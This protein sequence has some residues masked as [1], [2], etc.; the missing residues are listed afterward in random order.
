MRRL[1][2]SLNLLL[3]VAPAGLLCLFACLLVQR[4]W[5]YLNSG[6]RLAGIFS[7]EATRALGREVRVQSV[8]F[9]SNPWS[10]LPNR[11]ELG[12]LS[13]ANGPTSQTGYL[14]RAERIVI[15]YDLRQALLTT[16]PTVPL[17]K[18]VALTRPLVSLSRDV[19]GRWNFAQLIKPS[20]GTGRSFT[21][22]ITFTNAG[23]DY[24]DDD[25]PRPAGVARQP[26]RTSI[27]GVDGV[28]L[29]RPDK[30]VAFDVM[31]RGDPVLLRDFHVIGVTTPTP[32]RIDAQVNARDLALSGF[33]RRL[34]PPA[35]GRVE[36]G[37][38]DVDLSLLYTAPPNAPLSA[39]DL[40]SLDANGMVTLRAVTVSSPHLAAPLRD[41][42]GTLTLTEDSALGNL[43]GQFAGARFALT[44]RAVD[45]RSVV[46]AAGKSRQGAAPVPMV[47]LQG[48]VE[49]AD[50]GKI[51]HAIN[52]DPH[53][54][55]LAP[56]ARYDILNAAARGNL[57]F[58]FVGPLTD[59]TSVVEGHLELARYD[60]YRGDQIDLRAFYAH[61]TVDADARGRFAHGDAFV[62]GHVAA[63][64]TG[65]F[66]IEAHGRQLHLSVLKQILGLN[67][68]GVGQLD[69][70]I[71]GQRH[72][73]PSI[74][75]QGEVTGL[76]YGGQTLRSVYAYAATVGDPLI[77]WGR[78]TPDPLGRKKLRLETLR[79]DDA[80]GFA[81]A[82]GLL[83]LRTQKLNL[84]VEA[85]EL[86][87]GA[88]ASAIRNGARTAQTTNA[89]GATGGAA[90]AAGKPDSA[91]APERDA[92]AGALEPGLDLNALQGV[93]Y[94]RARVG[95]TLRHPEASGRVSAFA[96][97]AGKAGL[98]SVT[99]DFVL[100]RDTLLLQHAV[101]Q[102]YPGAVTADGSISDLRSSDPKVALTARIDNADVADLLDISGGL[103]NT[104]LTPGQK[105][106]YVVT[107]RLFA[108]PIAVTGTL[109]DLKLARPVT[110]SL[111]S[112]AINN[113]SLPLVTARA[114]YDHL[115][116]HLEE[117]RVDV[118]GG[119]ITARGTGGR[120]GLDLDVTGTGIG[121]QSLA[122]ALPATKPVNG[123]GMAAF[124]PQ[125]VQGAL[126][127][128]AHVG[129]TTQ[130]PQVSGSAAVADLG[131]R[132]MVLGNLQATAR[133]ADRR[134]S[135][136]SA[137]VREPN[138]PAGQPDTI[139]VD[140][141]A[142]NLQ[143]KTLGGMLRLNNMRLERA[144]DLFT[145]EALANT[146][147]G[148]QRSAFTDTLVHSVE[149][150]LSG[151][152]KIGG[153][154]EA[155]VA[156]VTW[157]ANNI[158]V[159]NQVITSITGSALADIHHL[160]IPSPEHPKLNLHIDSPDATVV[161]DKINYEFD[162]T[163]DGKLV[164]G[165]VA[166]DIDAYNVDL[167]LI[168]NWLP[169]QTR[170]EPFW[171]GVARQLTG[172]GRQIGVVVHGTSASPV[173]DVSA[174][175]ANL[176]YKGFNIDRVNLSRAT[177]AEPQITIEDIE[178][179]KRLSTED[180]SGPEFIARVTNGKIGMQWKSPFVPVL[181]EDGLFEI[182]ADVPH[183]DL[184]ALNA[185]GAFS[186]GN[187]RQGVFAADTTGA[188]EGHAHLSRV[189]GDWMPVGTLDIVSNLLHLENLHTGLRNLTAHLGF[190]GATVT[191]SGKAQ[192][193][194]YD[195][196]NLPEAK[197]AGGEITL[198]GSLPLTSQPTDGKAPQIT[199]DAPDIKVDETPI[200]GTAAPGGRGSGSL[201]SE[202]ALQLAM[203]R[204]LSQPL[205]A[206]TVN[207]SNSTLVP[208]G[209]FGGTG[210]GAFAL[211]INPEFDLAINLKN[212]NRLSNSLLNVRVD[213]SS[214]L[215]GRLFKKTPSLSDIANPNTDTDATDIT[216]VAATSTTG[217]N[218]A[219]ADEETATPANN[220]A[221]NYRGDFTV[222][223][224]RLTLPTA[225]FTLLPPGT[226]APGALTVR[227][228][229]F[230]PSLPGQQVLGF[231]VNLAAQTY[232]NLP[233]YTSV[234]G[235]KRYLVTVIVRGKPVNDPVTGQSKLTLN[236]QTDPP[237]F[238]GNQQSLQQL[239]VGVLGGNALQGIGR[240]PGQAIIQQFSNVLSSTVIP[241]IFD[242]PAEALGLEELAINYD[243]VQRLNLVLSRRII[244]SL[245]V[246]YIRYFSG[247]YG[248]YY[249]NF[250][251]YNIKASYRF[252]DRYQLSYDTDDQN[253]QRVLLEGVWRY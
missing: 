107:G 52:L 239:L 176:G 105:N 225:R 159:K 5:N 31:G 123:E 172:S 12:G 122:T 38:A 236:F 158:K 111:Q 252:N 125:D 145:S 140:G 22:R 135:V 79:V 19:R 240:N 198:S 184:H 238:A 165:D 36:G 67:M 179:T 213:G 3:L 61:R 241:G 139:Q 246:T 153:S 75:A 14:A 91:L 221:L 50:Y 151:T 188:F 10:L 134:V 118:A 231:D 88:L 33:A 29:I 250:E 168:R 204:S 104:D 66:Q 13:V 207:I 186:S 99:T 40:R 44:G 51:V 7:V 62:R 82:N 189:K 46:M 65:L 59:P 83:D 129:G 8:V 138:T 35:T 193:Y 42:T 227:Y 183:Q 174:N 161:G 141:L 131:Y 237:D 156:D 249:G 195:I 109:H 9:K 220:I 102:R 57:R 115:G 28:A 21:D 142:F 98:D 6:P 63:D 124:E 228:P 175:F 121:L 152:L 132:D 245:Y 187:G 170:R 146:P 157:K 160:E 150:A 169:A 226:L 177:I 41:L 217:R 162:R 26:L 205:V 191:A 190:N 76:S 23:V 78:V 1:R 218:G 163:V 80:R 106:P 11:L 182:D 114:T 137:G 130:E 4:V 90:G 247:T 234:S 27:E 248:S 211:P 112:A 74:S 200:P 202:V 253:V 20:T 196:N 210:G 197:R 100:N 126:S 108:D 164:H 72:V 223:D 69:F 64:P 214:R 103:P 2:V 60:H 73:T 148:A 77:Q 45:L 95:G 224:G 25:L 101:A 136:L 89:T 144:A 128:Q 180:P 244:G 235:R 229:D 147:V 84:N 194:I 233:T 155:P 86:D 181:P 154:F 173:I 49:N 56:K 34:L 171:M 92:G 85:D 251:T 54:A 178:L 94:L 209:Q 39:F 242:R 18:E 185:F 208:P 15:W 93:G 216:D 70:A 58:R 199:L 117:A 192:S 55:R 47:A 30:S 133:Y 120:H 206:G 116:V 222:R 87:L 71:Q 203:R 167:A 68:G 81:L 212:N 97:Q 201:R 113:L 110:V 143:Q 243:P 149:G 166:A 96:V 53:L 16:D 17:V 43:S 24:S 230:D 37:R 127:F 232:L 32:L 119:T 215:T 219:D 48:T